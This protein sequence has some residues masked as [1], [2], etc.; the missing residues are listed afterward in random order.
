MTNILVNAVPDDIRAAGW[1]VAVHNDYRLNGEVMTF[2]LFTRAGYCVKGEGRSDAEALDKV[3]EIIGL[4][5]MPVAVLRPMTAT[6]R[7][8]RSRSNRGRTIAQ[9]EFLDRVENQ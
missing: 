2:W 1:M 5:S 4:P 6:E 9:R 3:R 8:R 7:S